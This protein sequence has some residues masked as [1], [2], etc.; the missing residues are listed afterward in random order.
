MGSAPRSDGVYDAIDLDGTNAEEDVVKYRAGMAVLEK[1]L[2]DKFPA[3]KAQIERYLQFARRTAGRI[4]DI[5]VISKV[6]PNCFLF[7]E[8]GL[9]YQQFIGPLMKWTKKTANE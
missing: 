1:E 9:I 6:F 7:D 5:F 8:K 2:I 3:Q 4:T